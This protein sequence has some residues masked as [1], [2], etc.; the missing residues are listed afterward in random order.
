[1]KNDQRPCTTFAPGEGGK[2]ELIDETLRDGSQS[3][4]GMMM[5]YHMIEPVLED[6]VNSGFD[7]V[8]VPFHFGAPMLSTRFFQ[9]DPRHLFA[10]GKERMAGTDSNIMLTTLGAAVDI[11]GAPQNATVMRLMYEQLK[12]WIPQY[13][14]ALL[15]CCTEDEI[16][17]QYPVLFPMLRELGIEGVPYMA[18]GHGPNH[19]DEFYASR[20]KK[21]VENFQP[22]SICI[23]DVDGLLTPERLRGLIAAMQAEAKGTPLELH[24]HG[25]NGLNTYNAVVAM[26]MGIRRIT[27]CI[28]PLAN[29]SSHPSVFDVVKNAERMGIE[30]DIDIEKLQGVTERL[31]KIGKAYGHPVDNVHLPFDL[32]MYEHQI[33]G[34]VIS[35][36]TTQLEALGIPEALPEVLEEIPRILEDL[37]HPVMITP[38]SQF[39]VTQAVMNTQVG[40]W[41][42]CIDPC[43]ELAAGVYGFEE[44]GVAYMKPEIKDMLLSQP[45][46]PKIIE[47]GASIKEYIASTPSEEDVKKAVGLSADATRE[48]FVLR[49]LLRTDDELNGVTP[50]GPESYKKYL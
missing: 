13:N 47:K 50:G 12:E 25:M 33:P 5:S 16:D 8:N 1:M 26:E 37:G 42:Q 31:T 22:V 7:T 6:I 10:M 44:A 4:W 2:L 3:L 9:E 21:L 45:S 18:I 30:H 48:D 46:A 29:G 43:I 34:G 11:T 32:Q 23:K 27:T 28:P 39:I 15:I 40:R 14:R 20:V 36:T 38:F 17:N 35:N 24:T 19:T 41:E 49:Y